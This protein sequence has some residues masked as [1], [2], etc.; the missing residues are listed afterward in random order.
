MKRSR[1]SPEVLS[2]GGG[3]GEA[4]VRQC[5]AEGCRWHHRLGC[6]TDIRGLEGLGDSVTLS[7][8]LLKAVSVCLI[9]RELL[10]TLI[11]GAISGCEGVMI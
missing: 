11:L 7:D 4:G 6:E 1:C 5:G 10:F 3:Q 9:R 8:Y 2:P